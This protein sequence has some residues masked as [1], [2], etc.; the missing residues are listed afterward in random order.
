M[1]RYL[2]RL[3]AGAGAVVSLAD[4]YNAEDS[5][6]VCCHMRIVGD[7]DASLPARRTFMAWQH[8]TSYNDDSSAVEQVDPELRYSSVADPHAT[9]KQRRIEAAIAEFLADNPGATASDYLK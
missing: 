1:V 7:D 2:L 6:Q 5:W 4:C 8:S 3:L 9:V